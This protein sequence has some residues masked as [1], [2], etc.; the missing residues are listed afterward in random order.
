MTTKKPNSKKK[1]ELH[2]DCLEVELDDG[3][4][5]ITRSKSVN[6]ISTM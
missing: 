2:G 4:Y 6:E 3:I 5:R 1:C